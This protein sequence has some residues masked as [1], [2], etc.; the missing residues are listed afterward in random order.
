VPII[1]TFAP[2]VAG[3]GRMG[4]RRFLPYTLAGST[5]WI[6][7]MLLLG[8]TLHLWL[9]PILE[10]V[11]GRKVSVAKNIDKV[12]LVIIALSVLPIG[13][14]VGKAWLAKRKGPP[15]GVGQPPVP[16]A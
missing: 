12:I 8:Y 16:M 2:V 4:Y 3:I 5:V 15:S 10:G 7:S 13:Y 1:R 6:V 11:L 9:E 14:K